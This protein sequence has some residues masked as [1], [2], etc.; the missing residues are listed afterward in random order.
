V[1][2]VP[3]TPGEIVSFVVALGV[4]A[5]NWRFSASIA[6]T[7]IEI[8]SENAKLRA[9][10]LSHIDTLRREFTG[11]FLQAPIASEQRAA[12]V[13]RVE[14]LERN[15]DTLRERYHRH[16]NDITEK[17]FEQNADFVEKLIQKNGEFMNKIT[18]QQGRIEEA[19]RDKARRLSAVEASV[20]TNASLL[21]DHANRIHEL[22]RRS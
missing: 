14:Q 4:T 22:E 18:E 21:H 9:E 19:L 16:S 5:L 20:S 12:M 2:T 17:M 13:A 3:F 7:K 6:S 10:I 11:T 15:Y 1:Q 8:L